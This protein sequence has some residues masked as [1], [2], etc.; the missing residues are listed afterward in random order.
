MAQSVSITHAI[1]EFTPNSTYTL[2]MK[3]P[4][5]GGTMKIQHMKLE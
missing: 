5:Y 3:L 2:Y 1:M 4:H